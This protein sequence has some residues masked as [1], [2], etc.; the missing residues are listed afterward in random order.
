MA[1]QTEVELEL[2]LRDSSLFVEKT[3]AAWTCS[4][5]ES[6]MPSNTAPQG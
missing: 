3:P 4:L 6:R 2:A 1:V 5:R